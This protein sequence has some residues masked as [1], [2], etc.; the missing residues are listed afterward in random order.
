MQL[1]IEMVECQINN[2]KPAQ[3]SYQKQRIIT[4]VQT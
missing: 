4:V 2:K 1:H 3:T